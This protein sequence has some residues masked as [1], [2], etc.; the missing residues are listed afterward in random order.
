MLEKEN[1]RSPWKL[2]RI[3]RATD[4]EALLRQRACRFDEK[5]MQCLLTIGREGP[6]IREGG[7]KIFHWRHGMV[8]RRINAAVERNG[9]LRAKFFLQGGERTAARKTEHQI[10]ITQTVPRD[11]GERFARAHAR[12]R[13]GRVEIVEYAQR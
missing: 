5:L 6:E 4:D 1:V 3:L 10:K 11:V 12:Q 9:S 8:N 2:L 13:H 7:A